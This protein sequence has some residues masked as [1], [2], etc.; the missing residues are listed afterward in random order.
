MAWMYEEAWAVANEDAIRAT[1]QEA[2]VVYDTARASVWN[3]RMVSDAASGQLTRQESRWQHLN[4]L[5]ERINADH[6]KS[7]PLLPEPLWMGEEVGPVRV[8]GLDVGNDHPVH[9]TVPWIVKGYRMLDTFGLHVHGIQPFSLSLDYP[10]RLGYGVVFVATTIK[11]ES[12]HPVTLDPRQ[13]PQLYDQLSACAD[14]AQDRGMR[15]WAY[16]CAD[17]GPSNRPVLNL[18]EAEQHVHW[19][20]VHQRL[21][22]DFHIPSVSNEPHNGNSTEPNRFPAPPTI[23]VW[24]RGS[25][26][27]PVGP[28]FPQ[29]AVLEFEVGRRAVFRMLEDH[30]SV[31]RFHNDEPEGIDANRPILQAEGLF[32]AEEDIDGRR[33]N[34]PELFAAAAA[35]AAATRKYGSMGYAFGSDDSR[36]GKTPGP[37]QDK[38]ARAAIVALRNG[39]VL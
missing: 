35:F 8:M 4:E 32:A 17:C 31:A 34:D 6:G 13:L 2:G 22:G 11:A 26:G 30:A 21:V 20:K 37:N 38:C 5:R 27:D 39:F 10:A 36:L 12:G 19:M 24:S 16:A 33:A 3:A 18:S 9:G 29:G 25:A 7:L 14:I 15:L 28:N 23:S 1:Y